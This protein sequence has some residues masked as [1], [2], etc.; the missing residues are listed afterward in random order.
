MMARMR[1]WIREN[2]DSV[3]KVISYQD[4]DVHS[5]GIY[6]ADNWASTGMVRETGTWTNRSGRRG[7]ER[8]HRVRWEREP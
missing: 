4:C 1:K 2:M 5:G 8:K 6:K 7:T 3:E